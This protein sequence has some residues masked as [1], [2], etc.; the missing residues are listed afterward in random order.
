MVMPKWNV[1]TASGDVVVV[2][3]GVNVVGSFTAEV[4][5]QP[6]I[7]Q[8]G[9]Y[10]VSPPPTTVLAR[11]PV[12][13]NSNSGGTTLT[14]GQ[15]VE[16]L[17]KSLDGDIYIGSPVGSNMPYSGCGILIQQGDTITFPIGNFGFV[18]LFAATS[19]NRVSYGGIV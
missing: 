11:T 8:S 6:V 18:S 19:G 9:I 15:T 1:I 7:I 10:I 5:G 14:S 3:S 4:S 2:Q 13:I 12:P 17:I 16:V